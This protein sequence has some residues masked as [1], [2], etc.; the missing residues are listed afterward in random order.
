MSQLMSR[1]RCPS[2][3]L[4]QQISQMFLDSHNFEDLFEAEE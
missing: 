3:E 4:R 2:P 1:R